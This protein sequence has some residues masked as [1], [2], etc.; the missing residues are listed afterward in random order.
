MNDKNIKR[1]EFLSKMFKNYYNSA[2]NKNYCLKD[3]NYREFGF[4]YWDLN[5]F[6]RHLGF[7]DLESLSNH[8]ISKVP[9]HIYS[10]AARYK[11]PNASN[12][13]LKSY[14]DCELIFDLDID[15]FPTSCKD[16]HDK[17]ICKKC[18]TTGSGIAPKICLSKNCNSNSFKE[19]TWECDK[20]MEIA[21]NE[22]FFIIEEFLSKDFG[23]NPK[24][25]LYIVFSGRRGYHIHIEKE[26]FRYLDTNARREIV[27]YITGKGLVPSYHGFSL[28]AENKPN[29]FDN[30]WRGR[31][32]RLISRFL[33]NS[34]NE[35][36]GKIIRKATEI[37]TI[38]KN[39]ILQLNSR[40]PSFSYPGIGE[41]TWINLIDAAIN[42]YGAKI[43]Q[44]VTIDIHRLIR[45]PG[46]LHG[47][48]GFLVKKLSLN[49]LEKFDPFTHAQVFSGTKK[50]FVKDTPQFKI[51]NETFGPLKN[52]QVELPMSAA[53]FLLCRGL[54]YLS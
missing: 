35:E 23:L 31:I 27:D 38:K 30:G 21:K 52:K 1:Q 26:C 16:E 8:V 20:C 14:I 11:N 41:Q 54:A 19:I 34:G 12:M 29:I 39:L 28:K 5:K 53:V 3:I 17:W 36:V 4:F 44:P 18:H 50:I 7:S 49:E 46:S 6:V 51:G 24:Q 10:S 25:D 22:I 2:F 33:T 45:L 13:K 37:E 48:T 47:K 42:K 40:D 43:D 9:K 32:V 15:H